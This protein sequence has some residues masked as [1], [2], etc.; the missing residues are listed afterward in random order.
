MTS[1][2]L[3]ASLDEITPE[4]LTTALRAA[5][6]LSGGRVGAVRARPVGEGSGFIGVVARLEIAY[7]DDA[8]A[9]PRTCIVKLPSAD[10]GSRQVGQLYGLYEREVRFYADLAA[11]VGI[12]APRCYLSAYDAD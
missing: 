5:G 6:H 3:P 8:G 9:A 10:P 7:D 12:D 2:S 4:W 1:P 11:D